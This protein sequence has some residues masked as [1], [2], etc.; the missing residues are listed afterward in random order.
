MSA[1]HFLFFV[2]MA[3]VPQL[4]GFA[5][6]ALLALWR[7]SR[8]KGDERISKSFRLLLIVPFAG[9]TLMTV[10]TTNAIARQAAFL[11]GIESRALVGLIY[12][13]TLAGAGL[14]SVLVYRAYRKLLQNLLDA[15]CY[16]AGMRRE[17]SGSGG[18]KKT[19]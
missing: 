8:L 13:I 9:G 16:R 11:L 15:R 18:E 2:A 5:L 1:L 7:D 3:C 10:G 14:Y 19:A 17:E 12:I 6:S 4:V